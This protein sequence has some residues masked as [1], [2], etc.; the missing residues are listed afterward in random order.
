[1]SPSPGRSPPLAGR[2]SPAAPAPTAPGPPSPA[3]PPTPP[4]SAPTRR[5]VRAPPPAR[6]PSRTAPARPRGPPG[7]PPWSRP[8]TP[9]R[10]PPGAPPW[11][12]GRVVPPRCRR[13]GRGGGQPVALQFQPP[14]CPG[15]AAV[16]GGGLGRI[17]CR[18]GFGRLRQDEDDVAPRDGPPL[19]LPGQL[20]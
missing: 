4:A 16:A 10:C 15:P 14:R 3:W 11:G 9:F 1:L 19:H 2:P 5:P 8:V 20:V 7:R 12:A 18:A 17:L 13:P 6:R